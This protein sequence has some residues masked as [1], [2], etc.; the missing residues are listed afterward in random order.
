MG[1]PAKHPPFNSFIWASTSERPTPLEDFH[2]H[3][4]SM[5]N[6]DK[7]KQVEELLRF[8][9]YKKLTFLTHQ[10]L[11]PDIWSK[12]YVEI[13][14]EKMS[15]LI[16][17]KNLNFSSYRDSIWLL[18]HSFFKRERGLAL[19][20]LHIEF[21]GEKTFHSSFDSM[22]YERKLEFPSIHSVAIPGRA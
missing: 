5:R 20:Q 8:K 18:F 10:M 7:L 15:K 17:Y 19:R 1:F 14:S 6:C 21:F 4:L 2:K 3:F 13:L 12:I 9:I 16:I 11:P 22:R